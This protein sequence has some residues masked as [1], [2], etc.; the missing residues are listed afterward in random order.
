MQK[1]RLEE[2]IEKMMIL[3][4]HTFNSCFQA[5]GSE[6]SPLEKAQNNVREEK[7]SVNKSE[8]T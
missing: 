6:Y 2:V 7:K 3:K 1:G 5:D 8:G 4:N